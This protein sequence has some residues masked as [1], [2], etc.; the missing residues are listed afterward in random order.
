MIEV[1]FTLIDSN[2][3]G[4]TSMKEMVRFKKVPVI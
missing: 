2:G 4:V 1:K 3:I